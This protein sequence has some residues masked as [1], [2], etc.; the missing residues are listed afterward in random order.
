[1]N[2]NLFVI[3]TD[4]I[5]LAWGKSR[6]QE[7]AVLSLFTPPQGCLKIWSKRDNVIFTNIYRINISD[8]FA[9]DTQCEIGPRLYEQ[10]DYRLYVKSLN[11]EE[12]AVK[13]V[14]PVI[15]AD[16][17]SE[18]GNTVVHGYINFRSQVGKS[19]FVV[20]VGGKPEFEFEIQVFPSKLDYE[21]DYF[22]MV[23]D[24]QDILS[25]LALEFL[26]STF[27]TGQTVNNMK[28]TTLEW[29]VL[30]QHVL[31]ELVKA[32]HY[33]NLH[34]IK[35]L[36]RERM[37][38]RPEKIKHVDNV[39]RNAVRKVGGLSGAINTKL[40][41]QRPLPT[42]DTP[43]HRWLALQMQLI[44]DKLQKVYMQ[45]KNCDKSMRRQKNLLKLQDMQE[46]I[47]SLSLLKPLAAV[48]ALP[49]SGF[50]SLQLLKSPGYREAYQCCMILTLGLR[51]QGGPLNL[52]VKNIDVLYEYW[53]YFAVLKLVSTQ[54]NQPIPGDQLLSIK[55]NGLQVLLERGR[56][57]SVLFNNGNSRKV[58]VT[59]NPRFTSKYM[60]IPQQPDMIVT[61]EDG[62]WPAFHLV[63]DA[64]YRVDASPEYKRRYLTPGPPEDAVNVLHRYRDAILENNGRISN[65]PKKTVVQAA[66]LFPFRES[67]PGQFGQSRLAQ[68]LGSIGIGAIP[69]LPGS[70]GYLDAWLKEIIHLD[71]WTTAERIIS[72]TVQ[73]KLYDWRKAASEIV[74]VGILRG[75][76]TEEHWQWIMKNKVYYE[77]WAKTQ[78][79]QFNVKWVSIYFPLSVKSSSGVYCMASVIDTK[80]VRRQDINTP[81]KSSNKDES[82]WQVLYQLGEFEFF[83][84]PILNVGEQR[85]QSF[86]KHRWTSRL[87]IERAKVV[88]ELLLETQPEWKLYELFQLHSMPFALKA[89]S[90]KLINENNPVGR[91]WFV[92]SEKI[93]VRYQGTGKFIIKDILAGREY[94]CADEQEVFSRLNSYEKIE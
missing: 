42:L 83:S 3:Q 88:K 49:P 9:N 85:R 38:V 19:T 91:A 66:A 39:V 18:E 41:E 28:N 31:D 27:S 81:W 24:V 8:K 34:P 10:I 58:R 56:T 17:T 87:A 5:K 86:Q 92:L 2:K 77:P 25:G 72:H 45:E 4:K 62:T 52:S 69:L 90:P 63:M 26:R 35:G 82:D 36:T 46:M 48:S 64:K 75:D 32:L 60:L 37:L 71:T 12:V 55:Q 11:G 6:Q 57:Q 68:A 44:R 89:D 1:M 50:A 7:P 40:Q 53:C 65:Q 22:N 54:L 67:S 79:R 14:D 47:Q 78:Q 29:V 93:C 43:E 76:N 16:L 51:L 73:D 20:M 21:Q 13:H 94:I 30:L 15:L 80:L 23:A 74:L 84:N 33:I 59:Y 61:I 70:V